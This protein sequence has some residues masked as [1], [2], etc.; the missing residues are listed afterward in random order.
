MLVGQRFDDYDG[1]SCMAHSEKESGE[2][3]FEVGLGKNM[4]YGRVE[5][6]FE[7]V[8]ESMD[9]LLRSDSTQE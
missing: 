5:S 7:R 3:K 9:I 6:I 8:I 2:L 1:V 4:S